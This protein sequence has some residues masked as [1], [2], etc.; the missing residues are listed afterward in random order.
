MLII[1]KVRADHVIDHAAEELKKY[2]RM[3][4]PESGEVDICYAPE[5]KD[6]FRLGLLEDFGLPNDVEDPILDDVIHVDT[7]E[8]GGILAGSNMRSILF[9]VYRFLRENGCRWLYPG[10]DGEYIPTIDALQPVSWHKA[11]DHRIRGFCDEGCVSQENMLECIDFYP[12]L[13]LNTFMVEWFIPNG[14]YNRYYTHQHNTGN[15]IPEP[16]NDTQILRWRRHCETEISKRGLLLFAI[17][18][19][20]TCKA[21]GLPTNNSV[22]NDFTYLTFTEEQLAAFAMI[23]GER[24]MFRKA[25]LFTQICMSRADLRSKIADAIVDYA[26]THRNMTYLRV[27]LADGGKNHCECEECRK[28]R[29]ADWFWKILNE[30]DEKL[31]AKNLPTRLSFSSYMDTFFAPQEERLK[32]P[33]RFIMSYAPIARDYCSSINENSVIPEPTPYVRNAWER[34]TTT[35]AGYALFREYQKIWKGNVYCFEYHFWRHQFLDPGGLALA[36]RLH[37]DVRALKVMGIRGMAEDGSQRSAWPNAFATYIYAATLM[38]RD[39]DFDTVAEDYFSHAYGADW[40]QA[41]Q[42]LQK[43]SDAFDF[44][45]MEGTKSKDE[46]ISAYYNPDHVPQLK[47]VYELAALERNMAQK[48]LSMEYR[49][50]TISWRLLLRHAEYIEKWAAIMIAKAEGDNYK[51]LAM[52]KDFCDDFGRHEPELQRYF[53]HSLSCRVL[54]HITRKPQGIILD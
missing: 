12:K 44:A 47:K 26:E 4:M 24:K 19:G 23:N 25:P 52:A 1:N 43:I 46:Q 7:T 14:Y 50:Q 20:W 3:M 16:A 30:A 29:P 39:V 5:A 41:M 15:F 45:Y 6:G 35:E 28:L 53:D 8:D 51:A 18:H 40:K 22:N 49:P 42:L 38:N 10:I 2:L 37:E 34:P 48:H 54:E 17:G 33:D 11:A 13:E 9:A 21:L 31:T 32:N 36:R 27:S